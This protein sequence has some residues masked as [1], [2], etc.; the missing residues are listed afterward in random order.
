MRIPRVLVSSLGIFWFASAGHTA[1]IPDV[2][3]AGQVASAI[4]YGQTGW[5]AVTQ[6]ISA[7][8]Q[9]RATRTAVI[10]FPEFTL[11]DGTTYYL[12][13]GQASLKFS[14]KTAGTISFT[15]TAYSNTV[16]SPPFSGFSETSKGTN[17]TVQFSITFA[18]N[19]VL[20]ITANFEAP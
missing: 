18:N 4:A 5:C 6:G 3:I 17:Y 15:E 2:L 1:P 19:C 12:L 10:S 20:P 7:I 8:Q 9:N 11:F 16:I 14:S 13:N